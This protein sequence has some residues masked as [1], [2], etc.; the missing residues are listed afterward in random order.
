MILPQIYFWNKTFI[1]FYHSS[2]YLLFYEKRKKRGFFFFGF[3]FVVVLE[4][5]LSE[6]CWMID[7]VSFLSGLKCYL[8]CFLHPFISG[9]IYLLATKV[10]AWADASGF[11]AF[12][13]WEDDCA[14]ISWFS[15]YNNGNSCLWSVSNFLLEGVSL[16]KIWPTLINTQPSAT[17]NFKVFFKRFFLFIY[18]NVWDR[19]PFVN[20][21]Q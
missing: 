1:A 7:K 2:R 14:T 20:N 11:D 12:W 3:F 21:G 19:L 9:S 6:W 8:L 5:K 4:I 18:C 15:S 10:G 16:I 13:V 17:I